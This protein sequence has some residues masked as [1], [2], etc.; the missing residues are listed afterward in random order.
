MSDENNQGADGSKLSRSC[1]AACDSG[2]HLPFLGSTRNSRAEAQ[3][4]ADLH[5]AT[6]HVQGA[7]VVCS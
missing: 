7:L 6:C 1:F 3:N 4:E 5:N 2:N